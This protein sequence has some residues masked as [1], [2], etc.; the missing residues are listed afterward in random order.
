MNNFEADVATVICRSVQL[1]CQWREKTVAIHRYV[2]HHTLSLQ[3]VCSYFRYF[4]KHHWHFWFWNTIWTMDIQQFH[5]T[6]KAT[7]C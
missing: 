2:F 5:S 1:Q 7:F 3:L 6:F 4:A